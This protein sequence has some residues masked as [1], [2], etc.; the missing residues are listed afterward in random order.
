[1]ELSN[2]L[3]NK[4]RSVA[5]VILFF[6]CNSWPACGQ[7]YSIENVE[8]NIEENN[9]AVIYYDL[10]GRGR[11]RKYNVELFLMQESN[12]LFVFE[13]QAVMGEIGKG[14]F[15]GGQNKIV[16]SIDHEPS[17]FF[18]PDP[19]IDDYYFMVRARRK[20][21]AG[22]WIFTFLAGGAAYYFLH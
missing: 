2:Q 20:G 13:P 6:S 4:I 8:F 10:G 7:R 1:M 19:F 9:I 14:R 16:W 11:N 5:I 12:R 17:E 18:R 22:W 3:I 21:R 15:E